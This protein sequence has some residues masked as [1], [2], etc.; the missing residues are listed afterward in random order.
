MLYHN[1]ETVQL[2]KKLKADKAKIM[3]THIK[4]MKD[5]SKRFD[6]VLEELVKLRKVERQLD[7]LLSETEEAKKQEV[8]RQL[9]KKR[10]ELERALTLLSR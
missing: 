5:T 8:L 3:K 6:A 2:I 9:D 7:S 10:Q 1:S 4:A